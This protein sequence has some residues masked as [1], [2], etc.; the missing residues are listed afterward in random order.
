MRSRRAGEKEWTGNLGTSGHILKIQQGRETCEVN[1][2]TLSDIFHIYPASPPPE[3]YSLNLLQLHYRPQCPE[4]YFFAKQMTQNDRIAL[5][6]HAELVALPSKSGSGKDVD[7]VGIR[8]G[9]QPAK[10]SH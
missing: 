2:A 9:T 7:P 3:P 6:F 5:P 8:N 10:Y 1:L 4:R